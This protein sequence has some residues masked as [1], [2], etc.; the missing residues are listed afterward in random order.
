MISYN[1]DYHLNG[2]FQLN[3]HSQR[4]EVVLAERPSALLQDSDE[5]VDANLKKERKN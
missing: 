4:R 5:V 1:N 3:R 2:F